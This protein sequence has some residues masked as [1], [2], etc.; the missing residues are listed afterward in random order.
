MYD[1]MMKVE[2]LSK[3]QNESFARVAVAAF[4][5][6]LD[7]T[8]EEITDI[9]T[10]V[11]EAVTNSIIHGYK[12]KKD[13]IVEITAELNKN[14]ITIII[15]DHGCGID[16]IEQA[17]EPLYTSRPDLERSGMG[18]T[19][20]ETFMDS[21]EIESSKTGTKIRMKKKFKSLDID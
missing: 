10:A 1:N 15:V 12:D 9:K 19:V 16:D 3:S 4:A 21:V 2:F 17:R 8:I 13:G 14:E 6:Q 11:S 5:S 18:F 20:M 7:P